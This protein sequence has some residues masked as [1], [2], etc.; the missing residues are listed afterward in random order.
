M[1]LYKIFKQYNVFISRNA[2]KKQWLKLWFCNIPDVTFS[3][4]KL[5]FPQN[6]IRLLQ[7]LYFI[8]LTC[9]QHLLVYYCK[10]FSTRW[11]VLWKLSTGLII[12]TPDFANVQYVRL[13]HSLKHT[14]IVLVNSSWLWINPCYQGEVFCFCNRRFFA[15]DFII[16][17][18]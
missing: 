4:R 9:M 17:D 14:Q 18:I 2:M 1:F 6:E 15:F 12:V 11:K 10:I 7:Q 8:S 3:C 13:S 5:G 16:I